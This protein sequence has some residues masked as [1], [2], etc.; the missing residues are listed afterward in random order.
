MN[1]PRWISRPSL[2][3]WQVRG[4]PGILQRHGVEEGTV[5]FQEAAMTD[6]LCP[7]CAGEALTP[8]MTRQGVEIDVCER[9]RGVWLDRGEI[10]H[11]TR[12]ARALHQLLE[13]S[14]PGAV[15]TTRRSPATGQPMYEVPLLGGKLKV[16]MC[17]QSGGLWLDAGELVTLIKEGGVGVT[18]QV[19]AAEP[20]LAP[21]R[22]W[23]RILNPEPRPCR[24]CKGPRSPSRG[25][26]LPPP[27]RAPPVPRRC[28]PSRRR[29]RSRC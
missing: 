15:A 29:L 10:Y 21:H 27:C 14:V 4:G 24:P 11:F 1:W 7:V 8:R 2:G 17:P 19:P 18:L 25:L 3:V 13:A 26:R 28:R 23:S 16:E 20:A 22:C 9:C 12:Q 5:G 6:K